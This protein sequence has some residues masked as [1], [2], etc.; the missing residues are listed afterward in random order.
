MTK[1]EALER[2]HG[3]T[4]LL[5]DILNVTPQAIYQWEGDYI[6]PLQVYR[7]RELRPEWFA[8]EKEKRA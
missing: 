4:R 3:N 6:P 5:A 1:T 8:G 7:L 2:V